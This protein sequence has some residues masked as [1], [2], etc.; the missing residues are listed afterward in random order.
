MKKFFVILLALVIVFAFGATAMAAGTPTIT[1]STV[2]ET[3]EAGSE[4]T[5]TVTISN[6]P[7]IA[8]L[9]LPIKYDENMLEKV[10]FEGKGLSGWTI[11]TNATWVSD[12]NSTYN[13]EILTLKFKVKDS[14]PAGKATVTIENIESYN[15]D[16]E[17]VTFSVVPGGATVSASCQHN[18]T[19]LRNEKTATCSEKGYTGDTYCTDCN[20]KIS[21]GIET[22]ENPSNHGSYGT[23]V[24]NVVTANCHT[25]GYTGDT[26]CKGCGTKISDGTYT[27]TDATNHDGETEIKDAVKAT[28]SAIGYSGNTYC[29]GCGIQISTGSEIPVDPN[30]HELDNPAVTK[31]PTC[32]ESGESKITC[33]LCNNEVTQEIPALG[34][35]WGN[36]VTIKESTY[37]ENGLKERTCAICNVSEQAEIPMLH[38]V[39]D[40]AVIE[41]GDSKNSTNNNKTE[42]NPSTGASV[43]SIAGGIVIALAAAAIGIKIKNSH[44]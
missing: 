25:S 16:E 41:I 44:Y 5:V 11:G 29:K 30:A 19:E 28:C 12:S 22:D 2:S 39:E 20:V 10:S 21:S 24:K 33:K 9:T 43:A 8:V 37:A 31:E 18:N 27:G 32:T 7:G 23:T 15:I 26:Y 4:I 1:V 3:V 17:A 35:S 6:N 38:K 34:H 42:E 36:W 14:A 40:T 13:G